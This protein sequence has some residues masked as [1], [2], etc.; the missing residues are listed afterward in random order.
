LIR[1]SAETYQRSFA[2]GADVLD[3]IENASL[4]VVKVASMLNSTSTITTSEQINEVINRAELA[5]SNQGITGLQTGHTEIDKLGG[6]RQKGHLIVVA[7]RPAMGKTAYALCQARNMAVNGSSVLFV[8]LE[9]GAVEMMQRI[10]SMES[11]VYLTRFRNG[12]ITESQWRFISDAANTIRETKLRI[13]DDLHTLTAIRT[14]ARKMKESV[15]LDAIFI[16][17]IQ[18]VSNSVSG[19]SRE[20]EVSEI[21]RSLKLMARSLDVPVIALSQLSRAVETRAGK[22]PMLSDLRESGS[23]E[24]DA[25]IVEFL[26]R[27]EYYGIESTE[28]GESTHG[29]AEVIVAKNRFGACATIPLRFRHELTKFTDWNEQSPQPQPSSMRPNENFY[30]VDRDDVF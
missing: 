6:G 15:G 14:E 22:R 11:E 30:E 8:S 28:D 1:I 5:A 3:L 16:D 29:M 27:P 20:N 18:L 2:V 12:E 4:G 21:S 13:V 19:R 7:G 17:Y 26:F 25:D 24:Q 9:M 23:I 10:L